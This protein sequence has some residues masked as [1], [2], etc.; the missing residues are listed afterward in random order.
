MIKVMRNYTALLLMVLT[1]TV[2]GQVAVE[3]VSPP[4][5]VA[6][7]DKVETSV[8]SLEALYKSI[9]SKQGEIAAVQRELQ[10]DPDEVTRADL[11]E[12]LIQLKDE[13]SQLN[14]QFEEFAVAIDISDFFEE[15]QKE[16]QWQEELGAV[17]QPIIAEI[18]N[19]TA[20]SRII[21]E[22]RI[23]SEEQGERAALAEQAVLNLE[24]LLA[25]EP[26]PE[27]QKRLRKDLAVWKS[28]RETAR[29][30]KTALDLQLQNREEER[31][32]LLESTTGYAET[33][34]RTRGL[35]LVLGI[36][37]FCLVFFGVRLLLRL[38]R[39]LYSSKRGESFTS[40]LG[41]LLIHF[42]SIVGGML[43]ALL[44]FNMVGDWF[45]MG[46]MV[47]FLLGLGWTV[48]K[49]LPQ[50]IETINLMLNIGSVKEGERIIFNG[51]PWQVDRLGF[52]ATLINPLLDGG[53]QTMPVKH[54]VGLNSRP[55]GEN[56]EL[57]PSR[58]GDWVEL[59]DGRFGRVSCQS[60]GTVQLTELGGS[61]LQLQTPDY[62]ALSPRNLSTG[63][64]VHTT[65]GIDYKHQAESTKTIPEYMQKALETGLGKLLGKDQIRN[66][67]V[68]LSAAG[69]SSL[70]YEI[71][72]DLDGAAAAKKSVIRRAVSQLLVES[73]NQNNWGI[74][75]PQLTLHK[76]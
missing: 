19:A 69:A 46:I 8:R 15:P 10:A 31:K 48:V 76:A 27:L 56:E 29:N 52:G 26:S 11:L 73:C 55:S 70:D 67:R 68:E 58:P 22:L 51:I 36:G 71:E 3:E 41:S 66:I 17:I 63:F 43:A 23:E 72:V 9:Q 54:L 21:N 40:R 61:Q 32:S 74:P 64:R 4:V 1:S 38:Y 20:D 42:F 18:K 49:T 13:M 60:P 65:F 6:G 62:L 5:N 2:L 44:V 34:F 16:F 59:A 53:M 35:N 37:A 50:H 39:R 45:L 47:I 25:A 24:P 75:F 57:F 12:L 33:F 7:R 28:R 30:Q 14:R